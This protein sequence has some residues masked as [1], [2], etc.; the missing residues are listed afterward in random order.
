MI[1]LFKNI[2]ENYNL[3]FILTFRTFNNLTQLICNM[4]RRLSY[5]D[6]IVLI[7]VV[8]VNIFI[9]NKV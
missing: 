1:V 7:I 8:N 3:F 5:H 2:V 9:N 6:H 4:Y